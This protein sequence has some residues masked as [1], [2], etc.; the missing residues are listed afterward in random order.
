MDRLG[1]HR[2]RPA[3]ASIAAESS[4]LDGKN[5]PHGL[6]RK[7]Q[8][9]GRV[10]MLIHK[11]RRHA[12][13]ARLFLPRCEMETS[14]KH[15]DG[16]VARRAA[17]VAFAG[18][19]LG[20]VIF[21][22]STFNFDWSTRDSRFLVVLGMVVPVVFAGTLTFM[23]ARLRGYVAVATVLGCAAGHL[24]GL[25]CGFSYLAPVVATVAAGVVASMFGLLVWGTNPRVAGPAARADSRKEKGDHA[26][27]A[28][29]PHRKNESES[30]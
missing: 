12:P 29:E 8:A 1:N 13:R 24:Y 6:C 19:A 11:C 10:I 7:Q 26:V 14:G 9:I 20:I 21:T 3:I 2:P 5:R 22:V 27:S 15:C 25:V 18:Y 23:V 30:G 28:R 4:T 16:K 17:A